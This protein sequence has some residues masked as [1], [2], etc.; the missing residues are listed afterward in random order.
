MVLKFPSYFLTVF[1][2]PIHALSA[3]QTA[4]NRSRA[5]SIGLGSSQK[6]KGMTI[7]EQKPGFQPPAGC[8]DMTEDFEGRITLVHSGI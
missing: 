7:A 8:I 4:E 6:L 1:F 3:S 2:V 5:G